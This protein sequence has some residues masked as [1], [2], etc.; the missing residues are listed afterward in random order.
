MAGAFAILAKVWIPEMKECL[1]LPLLPLLV[2][3]ANTNNIQNT[4]VLTRPPP[5]PQ[6]SNLVIKQKP[7]SWV[8]PNDILEGTIETSE[9]EVA[10][11]IVI[12]PERDFVHPNAPGYWVQRPGAASNGTWTSFV[13]FGDEDTPLGLRFDIQAFVAPTAPDAPQ[14]SLK[15]GDILPAFPKDAAC[16]SN[17][18]TV[19][20]RREKL[21]RH[22]ASMP[23][24]VSA[25]EPDVRDIP[26][27]AL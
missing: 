8:I 18:V 23:F 5:P 2:S 3:C 26:Y 20:L 1:L 16:K 27:S 14:R 13:N 9:S 6:C 25:V 7:G 22:A 15:E 12:R 10:V 19:R 21:N 17:V 11:W 4:Q 24:A